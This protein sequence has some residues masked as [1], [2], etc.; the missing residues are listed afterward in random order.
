MEFFYVSLLSKIIISTFKEVAIANQ[1]TI[2]KRYDKQL[3]TWING[4]PYRV[5][6][7]INNFLS[8]A[9][10]FTKGGEVELAIELD[11]RCE[12]SKLKIKI[13]HKVGFLDKRIM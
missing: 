11:N 1:V 9:I 12:E 5:T 8:N 10:K 3:P 7:I 6:Q 4:D 2:K 13:R